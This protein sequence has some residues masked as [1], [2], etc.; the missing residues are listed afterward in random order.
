[1]KTLK[2]TPIG[3]LIESLGLILVDIGTRGGFDMDLRDVAWS[4]TAIGFEP[5][6]SEIALLKN[7]KNNTW[8]ASRYLSVAIGGVTGNALL[9]LPESREGASLRPHNA[10]LIDRFG[11]YNLH[12]DMEQ[13]PVNTITLDQ[14]LERGELC[15]ADFL[16]VDIEGVELEVLKAGTNLLKNCSAVKVECSFLEQ[17]EGQALIWDVA[18]FLI[19][20]GFD[21][22]DMKDINLWRRR[23]IPSHPFRA[24]FEKASYSRG[25]ISQCDL[26]GLR[27]KCY[28]LNPQDL[29]R[30]IIISSAL[31]YFDYAFSILRKYPDLSGIVFKDFN[32]ELEKQISAWSKRKG[33]SIAYR[34]FW[35]NVRSFV[36]YLRSLLTGLPV[37]KPKIDF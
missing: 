16:K 1:M 15:R 7:T 4:T 25:Q 17:R 36:T 35:I 27:G 37:Q 8:K 30:V 34:H 29:L 20:Q 12:L 6:P 18:H 5:D 21:I 33:K 9:Y 3:S 24:R 28:S 11:F 26:I 10:S 31:G 32:F 22:V 14:L 23:P 13:I 2:N 19:K